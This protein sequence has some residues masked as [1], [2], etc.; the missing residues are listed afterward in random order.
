MLRKVFLIAFIA[1]IILPGAAY[2]R[3][4][5]SDKSFISDALK[6]DNA[7]IALGR[8]AAEKG[9]ASGVR[10]FGRTLVEDHENAKKD[11]LAVAS[12]IGVEPT[13][14]MPPDAEEEENKLREMSGTD[15]DREFARHMTKDHEKDIAKFKAQARGDGTVATLAQKTLPVL[16]KH[17]AMARNLLK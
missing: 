6:G 16:Q 11:A 3:Q 5:S 13:D 9:S 14:Q 4:D 8:L 2:A 12:E 7:E 1:A 17:L 10:A 15:F